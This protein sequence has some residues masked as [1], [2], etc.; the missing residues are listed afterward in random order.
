MITVLSTKPRNSDTLI[1]GIKATPTTK[2]VITLKAFVDSPLVEQ[3]RK[4][5]I[6]V[7]SALETAV[8]QR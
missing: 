1:R 3:Q 7:C 4:Y 5:W 2:V 6:T 8:N